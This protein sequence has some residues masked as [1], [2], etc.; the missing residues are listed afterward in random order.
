MSNK[1]P[2]TTPGQRHP[3]FMA[4]VCGFTISFKN[5]LS[6]GM[7]WRTP[8]ETQ[9]LFTMHCQGISRDEQGNTTINTCSEY[10]PEKRAF[11]G[12]PRGTCLK[13]YCH[14]SGDAYQLLNKVNKP[15]LGCPLNKWQKV[16][17]FES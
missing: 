8:A 1:L 6:A 10:D 5:W 12:W 17:D 4:N 2:K 3:G 16:I 11:P 7:P 14:V 13:C 9:E 15:N